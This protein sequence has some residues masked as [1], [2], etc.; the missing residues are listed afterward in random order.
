MWILKTLEKKW[1]HK[2]LSESKLQLYNSNQL[3]YIL[4]PNITL[5]ISFQRYTCCCIC[6]WGEK[7]VVRWMKYGGEMRN[8][9]N[10]KIE[11]S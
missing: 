2:E 3:D 5:N 10:N 9:N 7:C 11:S 4:I 6:E 8:G 1:S